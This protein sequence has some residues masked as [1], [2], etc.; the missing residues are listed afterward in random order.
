MRKPISVLQAGYMKSGNYWLWNIIEAALARAGVRKRSYVRAQPIY[1]VAK[2]WELAFDGESGIDMIE[3][4]PHVR[5]YVIPPVFG[6]PIYDLDDYV[7]RCSH[8]WTHSDLL[9]G[10]E[11]YFRRFSKVVAIFR[12]PRDVALSILRFDR[13]AFRR[14][15]YGTVPTDEISP[16]RGWDTAVEGYVRNARALGI[17]VVFYERL[18][19]DWDA[20]LD[21]LLT[22]LEL[23]I[24][25]NGR[26]AIGRET[27][28]AEMKK[29]SSMHLAKGEAFGWMRELAPEAQAA[30]TS[31]HEPMLRRLR[32][33]L[34]ANPGTGLP[35]LPDDGPF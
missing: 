1:G 26:G 23:D 33:P 21:R 25:T 14:K 10:T 17:H 19:L 12:D 3:I 29:R 35:A 31:I 20:E 30:L 6:W 22:Y 4:T 27:R 18:V 28:F 8:V 24:D 11:R 7:R 5:R 32:Y 16:V 15:F 2:D 9:P 13:N 34:T